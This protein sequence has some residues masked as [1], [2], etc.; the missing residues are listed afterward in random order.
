MIM[1]TTLTWTVTPLM[2]YLFGYTGVAIGS[3]V[4]ALTSGITILM[5]KE[6]IKISFLDQIWR[7]T[8]SSVVMGGALLLTLSYWSQ[9]FLMLGAGVVF[10]AVVYALVF[11]PLGYKKLFVELKTLRVK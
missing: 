5:V 9:S 2:V 6:Y 10:G 4:I 1:W 3:A 8:I 11:L 7:Q